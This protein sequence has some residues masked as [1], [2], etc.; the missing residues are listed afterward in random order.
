VKERI[1]NSV[2]QFSANLFHRA[3]YRSA[4][5]WRMNTFLGFPILQ[6]PFDLQT[7]Q[8]LVYRS[9]PAFIVQ[10]GVARGGS[11]LYFATLLDLIGADASALV[12]G[13]DLKLT[14]QA[15]TLRHP[16]IRM[17]EASSTDPTAVDRVR[18]FAPSASGA[19][20]SLDSDHRRDH[21][22]AELRLY[23]QFVA[24]GGHLVVED[25]NVN[26]HPVSSRH[27]PGP[28]EAVGTFLEEHTEFTRDD[29]LWR[30]H[31][32]S[33]HQYGWLRRKDGP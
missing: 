4:D 21:V 30:R 20:V 11:L 5:S 7:Y 14:E 32:F 1:K 24:P 6:C 17:I 19:L 16:R 25:T 33:F 10:T 18:A 2:R 27:G 26:G 13:V 22:L 3:Y 23:S 28:F 9:P 8:E 15:K 29:A 31:L 12:I